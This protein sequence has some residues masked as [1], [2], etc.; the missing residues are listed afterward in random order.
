M[1]INPD[2]QA[3]GD[4]PMICQLCSHETK[5]W[6]Y[7]KGAIVCEICFQSETENNEETKDQLEDREEDY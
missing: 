3:T 7:F 6:Y 5:V 2:P 1:A 4:N